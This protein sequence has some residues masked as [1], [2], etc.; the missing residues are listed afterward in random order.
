MYPPAGHGS[1]EWDGSFRTSK[2]DY[3]TSPTKQDWRP[4]GLISGPLTTRTAAKYVEFIKKYIQ[5]DMS[6][7]VNTPLTWSPEKAG[8][9]NMPWCAQGTTQPDGKID[10]ES[11]RE[12]LLG[13]YTGQ[14]LQPNTFAPPTP[15]PPEAFQNHAVIYYNPTAATMLAEVWRD[16]FEPDVSAAQFPEGS[17]VVKVEA[18]TLT[19]HQW[20]PLEGS[21]VSYVYRPTTKSLLN[22]SKSGKTAEIVPVRF[23]QMAVKVKDRIASPD[24]GWVFIAFAYDTNKH[25]GV[26]GT[27]VWDKTVPVGAMWGNDP[28][29]SRNRKG[30]NPDGKP[31]KE[32]WL[33]PD[34]PQYSRDVLGWG[35]RLSGPMDVGRRHNVITVSGQHY[36]KNTQFAASSCLSCHGSAQYPFMA[37]LYPSPNL[38]FPE[39]GNQFLF[40]DPG[41][42]QWAQWFQN[43]PGNTAQSGA[44][45]TGITAIDYDMLLT[46]ALTAAKAPASTNRNTFIQNRLQGH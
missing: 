25:K 1:D 9:Y 28:E 37:N 16:P 20:P 30:R 19:P 42:D 2:Y 45:R 21:S 11:G 23:V 39:D 17:I 13:S 44:G 6:D 7:L 29:Y 27:T 3:P 4:K 24:T 34:A 12:A 18:A 46:F 31:L 14:I 36:Q 40:F 22:P 8:W 43:R 10:P 15:R 32:T 33:N 26:T 5:K 41:S 38:V 35:G